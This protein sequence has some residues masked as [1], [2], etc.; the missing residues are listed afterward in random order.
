MNQEYTKDVDKD[1]TIDSLDQLGGKLTLPQGW[2]F[3][4]RVLTNDLV[5][6]TSRSRGVASILRDQLGSPLLD[7]LE[8]KVVPGLAP[9]VEDSPSWP[10]MHPE[11]FFQSFAH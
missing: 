4:T 3:E 11:W 6:D 9:E 2:T 7:Y 5:L 10:A 8:G 1:L